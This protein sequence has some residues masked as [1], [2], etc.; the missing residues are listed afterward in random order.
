MLEKVY[1][2]INKFCFQI[3]TSYTTRGKT[4][5]FILGQPSSLFANVLPYESEVF[6]YYKLLREEK[7][8]EPV[9]SLAKL[10][11]EEV[12]DLWREKGNLPTYQIKSVQSK[13]EDIIKRGN[14]I[15]KIPIERRQS[16]MSEQTESEGNNSRGRKNKDIRNL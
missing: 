2:N 14:D 15:L 16:I 7:K 13:I 8:H 4:Q 12:V 5:H 9:K 6:N 3:M 1:E 10:I 11:A